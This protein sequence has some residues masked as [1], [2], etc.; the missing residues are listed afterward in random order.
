MMPRTIAQ[1]VFWNP[2]TAEYDG[3]VFVCTH[4]LL[5]H[6]ARMNLLADGGDPAIFHLRML[7]L[8]VK[9]LSEQRGDM[10]FYLVQVESPVVRRGRDDG[11]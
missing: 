11:I 5:E 4:C 9:G 8:N 1:G 10:S 7:A 3:R 2:F 6:L